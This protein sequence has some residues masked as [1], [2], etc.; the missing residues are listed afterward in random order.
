M[1]YDAILINIIEPKE[2]IIV[3]KFFILE[4]DIVRNNFRTSM[5]LEEVTLFQPT[6]FRKVQVNQMQKENI[7][8]LLN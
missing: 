4:L 1:K 8:N 5:F 3:E 7:L 2:L 6:S